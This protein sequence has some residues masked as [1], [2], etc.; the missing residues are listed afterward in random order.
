MNKPLAY[1][2]EVLSNYTNEGQHYPSQLL[3]KI[4]NNHYNTER[5]FVLDLSEQEIQYL[6]SILPNELSNAMESEDF[7]R[8]QQ[9]N[10]VYELLF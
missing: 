3:S 5:D 7:P 2:R 8:V 10:E 4:A 9:L 1:L 6:N